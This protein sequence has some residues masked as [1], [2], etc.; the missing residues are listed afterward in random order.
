[1]KIISLPN[2]SEVFFYFDY[3]PNKSVEE[4]ERE[5]EKVERKGKERERERKYT[6]FV[7]DEKEHCWSA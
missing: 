3:Q 2:H 4:R 6:V 5:R 1:M 7:V